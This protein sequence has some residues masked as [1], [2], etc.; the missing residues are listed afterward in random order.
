M[1][2]LPQLLTNLWSLRLPIGHEL[3]LEPQGFYERYFRDL[4]PSDVPN[5]L[6]TISEIETALLAAGLPAKEGR[7]EKRERCVRLMPQLDLSELKTISALDMALE[8]N[9][10][11]KAESKLDKSYRLMANDPNALV[12]D[13]VFSQNRLKHGECITKV[14]EQNESFEVYGMKRPIDGI[15][16]DDAHRVQATVL[17]HTEGSL[18]L[19]QGLPEVAI[20]ARCST[21]GMMLKVKF[22]WLRFDNDA[23]DLKTTLSAKPEEFR[24][25]LLK[26]HYDIQAA[27]YTYV[28]G[29][30][31]IVV[32][33]FTFVAVE[34]LHADICQPYTLSRKLKIKANSKLQQALKEFHQCNSTNRWYGYHKEDCTIELD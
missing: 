6:H 25:Q 28:A 32:D 16:W 1:L 3:C 24:R 29:L 34:Y 22:D 31:G 27:F 15:V 13:Y 8:D 12:F 23:V 33:D 26:L 14:D 2:C 10:F 17:K 18:Y 19:T 5:A 21:T 7:N 4:V 9:G 20:F 30:M 11:N